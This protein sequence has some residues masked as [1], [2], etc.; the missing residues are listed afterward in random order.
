M[1]HSEAF[2][3]LN[4]RGLEFGMS[5]SVLA[6]SSRALVGVCERQ[7]IDAGA[8]LGAVGISPG[9]IE[10]PEARLPAEQVAALWTRAG[11]LSRD[12]LLA[13]HAAK[14]PPLGAY[15]VLDC[16]AAHAPTIGR[17][18]ATVSEFFALIH[19]GI[20]LPITRGRAAVTVQLAAV[21]PGALVPSYAEYAL[22][23]VCLRVRAASSIGLPLLRVELS[24]AAPTNSEHHEQLFGCPVIFG[25]PASR[26]VVDPAVWDAPRPGSDALL[27]A[28]LEDHAALLV[29]RIPRRVG[30]VADV[31]RVLAAELR[32]G[33]PSVDRVAKTL[34]MSARTL[35]RRLEGERVRYRELLDEMREG[36]ARAYLSRPEV[37]ITE[38]AHLL[39]FS[40][41]SAFNRACK[42]W[43]GCSPRTYRRSRPVSLDAPSPR[44]SPRTRE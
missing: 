29:D 26:L 20:R 19:S 40:E 42:R 33:D 39:G 12:P 28:I 43:L 36:A 22:T 7:G 21:A 44:T 10:D 16:V 6:V 2:G 35:Q 32:G 3:V 31:R 23:S 11:E 1:T 4:T 27:T 8:L 24:R 5:G 34:G 38:A 17:A 30:V 41:L 14:L 9:V 37:S 15:R 13:L 18:I 25:A